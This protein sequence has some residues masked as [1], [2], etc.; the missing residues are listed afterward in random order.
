MWHDRY[1]PHTVSYTCNALHIMF[2]VKSR[3]ASNVQSKY[4]SCPFSNH[5][6]IMTASS[7]P[8]L[9]FKSEHIFHPVDIVHPLPSSRPPFNARNTIAFVNIIWK[10]WCMELFIYLIFIALN[11]SEYFMKMM[12]IYTSTMAATPREPYSSTDTQFQDISLFKCMHI[13][14]SFCIYILHYVIGFA[15][16]LHIFFLCVMGFDEF[17]AAWRLMQFSMNHTIITIKWNERPTII[18]KCS[19]VNMLVRQY[20]IH[21]GLARCVWVCQK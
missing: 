11:M 8:F 14:H 5:A 17:N 12:I 21:I 1:I 15:R 20:C 10:L 18:K 16:M 7:A 3:L 19:K 4:F 13:T 9:H 6:F 2:A